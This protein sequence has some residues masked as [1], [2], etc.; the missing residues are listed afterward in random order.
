VTPCQPCVS[1]SPAREADF[2]P[3]QVEVLVRKDAGQLSEESIQ[4]CPGGVQY[5]VDGTVIPV[6][7]SQQGQLIL[8]SS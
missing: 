5:W 2:V 6:R 4:E 3:A 1:H 7:K 8:K